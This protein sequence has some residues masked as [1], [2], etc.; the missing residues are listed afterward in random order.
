VSDHSN[1]YYLKAILIEQASY[2]AL[3]QNAVI[4]LTTAEIS[5]YGLAKA[6]MNSNVFVPA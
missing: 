2:P 6:G 1:H 4:S 3:G 5:S